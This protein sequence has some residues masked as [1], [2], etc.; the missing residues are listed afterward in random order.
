VE[1]ALKEAALAEK[2]QPQPHAAGDR[3]QDV[4][5]ASLDDEQGQHVRVVQVCADYKA[6]VA[7]SDLAGA[8]ATVVTPRGTFTA[9]FNSCRQV[10]SN[11]NDFFQFTVHCDPHRQRVHIRA[12]TP[13]ASLASTSPA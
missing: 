12:V 10:A 2:F 1:A 6:T 4:P 3:H 8:S 7:L 11:P 9:R 13:S 5:H